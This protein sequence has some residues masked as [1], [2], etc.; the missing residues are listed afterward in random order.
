MRVDLEHL[1]PGN[2]GRET[3]ELNHICTAKKVEKQIHLNRLFSHLVCHN[4]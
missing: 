4:H 3:G 1:F 2:G